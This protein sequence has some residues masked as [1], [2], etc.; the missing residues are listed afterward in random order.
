MKRLPE[1][2]RIREAVRRVLLNETNWSPPASITVGGTTLSRYEAGDETPA[3][4]PKRYAYG[5]ASNVI[6]KTKAELGAAN[7][8]SAKKSSAPGGATTTVF[9]HK[10]GDDNLFKKLND[11]M[12][13]LATPAGIAGTE[14]RRHTYSGSQVEE[15]TA[16][17]DI[18]NIS[19]EK[20]PSPITLAILVM[21]CKK[22]KEK[23]AAS[24]ASNSERLKNW[25]KSKLG[26]NDVNEQDLINKA[27][28]ESGWDTLI[29]E[30]ENSNV[31]ISAVLKEYLRV[32]GT[33]FSSATNQT[34]PAG[35]DGFADY[36][37]TM[38]N[39]VGV[40]P[41]QPSAVG[42]AASTVTGAVK[43]TASAVIDATTPD[44][45]APTPAASA[46]APADDPLLLFLANNV[47]LYYDKY[48]GN[49]TTKAKPKDALDDAIKKGNTFGPSASAALTALIETIE[50][51][52]TGKANLFF[53]DYPN[54]I[55]KLSGLRGATR[56]SWSGAGDKFPAGDQGLIRFLRFTYAASAGP[57]YNDVEKAAAQVE[58][59]SGGTFFSD[60][61]LWQELLF[62]GAASPFPFL[63]I[64]GPNN[65]M[66]PK[67][68]KIFI[69][70]GGA[71]P[72]PIP[73]GDA[74]STPTLIKLKEL[75]RDYPKGLVVCIGRNDVDTA[76][77]KGFS[78]T[79]DVSGEPAKSLLNMMGQQVR[80]ILQIEDEAYVL[81]T[82]LSYATPIIDFKAI[83]P[84]PAPAAGPSAADLAR[85]VTNIASR[86]GRTVAGTSPGF[87]LDNV[88][89][90]K[91]GSPAVRRTPAILQK[92][93]PVGG[94]D[95]F[96]LRVANPS[97]EYILV[98]V[99]L[100]SPLGSQVI[101]ES[102]RMLSEQAAHWVVD[103]SLSRQQLAAPGPGANVGFL[104]VQSIRWRSDKNMVTYGPGGFSVID[105]SYDPTPIP[106]AS[107][108]EDINIITPEQAMRMGEAGPGGN[109]IKYAITSYIV[110]DTNPLGTPLYLSKDLNT[111]I[112]NTF[113]RATVA[114]GG[115]N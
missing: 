106:R 80:F 8:S 65:D 4:Q 90:K 45:N 97:F 5:D 14:N 38:F 75:K 71:E 18:S 53:E 36:L 22:L 12:V 73:A 15:T 67:N 115:Y 40:E 83:V 6:L 43:D 57:N 16:L 99:R 47:D 102:R 79:P 81:V 113:R 41:A 11:T 9:A 56:P 27:F 94:G 50:E 42:A 51:R 44:S 24:K 25:F 13:A 68:A 76:T 31:T 104:P 3:G 17:E 59:R 23:I 62:S 93:V 111:V 107:L 58:I 32:A 33:D 95:D 21:L 110:S 88:Y 100:R 1:E 2:E 92:R 64:L 39:V 66:I 19:G 29:T 63:T 89:I 52:A 7:G 103:Y 46:P 72:G 69:E 84:K 98:P 26:L 48:T 77:I 82:T 37:L 101:S 112:N 91:D 54:K 96:E 20:D 55:N 49:S 114:A 108:P 86:P 74:P 61:P 78:I 34:A 28:K 60:D 70:L 30:L 109:P 105:A 85:E 87:E 10:S 35:V